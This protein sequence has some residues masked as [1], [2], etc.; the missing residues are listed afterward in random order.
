MRMQFLVRFDYGRIVPWVTRQPGCLRVTAGPDT[1]QLYTEVP[2]HGHDFRSTSEF[3]VGKGSRVPFVLT[4]GASHE[5][6]SAPIAAWYAVERTE[7]EWNQWSSRSRYTGEYRDAVQGSLTILK[8]LTYR[9]TGGIVAAATTSIP[10]QAGGSRN[11][12]YRYCWVRDAT[13]TLYALLRAGYTEEAVAWREWLLRAIAGKA[14][15]IQMLYGVGGERRLSEREVPWLPGFNG[16]SPVRIG[17]A[18]HEQLQL[19]VFGE[20]MDAMHQCR[21]ARLPSDISWPLEKHLLAFLAS[22]W[23]EPDSSIWEMRR[24][25]RQYTHSKV[26]AW[27]AFDRGIKAIESFGL[28]GPLAEWGRIRTEIHRQVCEEGFSEKRRSFVQ[29]YGSDALDASLLLI[30][31]VGFLPADDPRVSGTVAAIERELLIE[32]TFVRRYVTDGVID[33]L[34]PGEGAFIA[35]SFW[36]VVVRSMQGRTREAVALFERLL[37]LRNDVGMLAEEYDFQNE[38]LAGNFPQAYSH[39]ALIEA[40]KMLSEPLKCGVSHRMHPSPVPARATSASG[41]AD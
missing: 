8:A 30:P 39:L 3:E 40:A 35:C 16:A 5:R 22:R 11:W 7:A 15:Q 36:L 37:A 33:G 32:D 4:Y 28:E 31:M 27:V 19:D 29:T 2:V 12:D 14:E 25:P 9:P 26:M 34:P 41:A 38:C 18:A 23:K 10:E 1:L 24:S 20:L 17:N 13:V 6:P 21:H